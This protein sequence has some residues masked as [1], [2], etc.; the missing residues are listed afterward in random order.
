MKLKCVLSGY[1]VE[2][3]MVGI[4]C[5]TSWRRTIAEPLI[6][7]MLLCMKPFPFCVLPLLSALL[8]Q[9]T[10]FVVVLIINWPAV[11]SGIFLLF[12]LLQVHPGV[13]A[14]RELERC[15]ISLPKLLHGLGQVLFLS[16]LSILQKKTWKVLNTLI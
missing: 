12:C 5:L 4:G 11:I 9:L 10:F 16:V 13:G 7:N 3:A 8:A 6:W 1:Y 15:D 14:Q 2:Q